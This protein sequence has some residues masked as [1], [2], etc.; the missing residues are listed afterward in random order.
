MSSDL[1]NTLNELKSKLN[2]IEESVFYTSTYNKQAERVHKKDLKTKLKLVEISQQDVVPINLR[3]EVI[4]VSKSTFTESVLNT[5]V[6]DEI[7]LLVNFQNNIDTNNEVFIDID[8]QV[9]ST[10]LQILRFFNKNLNQDVIEGKKDADF[11]KYKVI[12]NSE[13]SKE[14]F[15]LELK[16]FFLGDEV[17]KLVDIN[18]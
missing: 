9:F 6:T 13:I 18:F 15:E 16:S 17:F 10:I 7:R 2:N 5:I 14:F 1:L 8:K 3:G 11:Q 4:S 12:L